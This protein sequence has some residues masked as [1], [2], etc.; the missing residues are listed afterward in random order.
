[1]SSDFI[2]AYTSSF[3]VLWVVFSVVVVLLVL[4]A[5]RH[6]RHAAATDTRLCRACGESHPPHARFCRK[7]GGA[8]DK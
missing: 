2:S 7:C 4:T 5:L 8:M 6:R 3:N 1:M